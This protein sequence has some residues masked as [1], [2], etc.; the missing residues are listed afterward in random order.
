M[1]FTVETSE[2]AEAEIDAIF[3]YLN[4][5][6]PEFAGRWLIGLN[7][8]LAELSV[9]PGRHPRV[10]NDTLRGREVRKA[11]YRNG[12]TVYQILFSLVNEDA[13][14]EPDTVRVLHVQ[15]GSRRPLGQPEDD[16]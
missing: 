2:V 8:S 5:R 3:L 11:L 14:G 15:N 4:A 16:Q 6:N 10:E 1:S 12:R 9:F 13:N 7:R